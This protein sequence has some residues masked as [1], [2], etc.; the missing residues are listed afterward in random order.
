MTPPDA[1]IGSP[2]KAPMFS[3]PTRVDR[4]AELVDQEVAERFDA[5]CPP[6]GGTDR[7]RTA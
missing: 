4:V 7:A 6:A 1:W 3:A 2:T 5:S